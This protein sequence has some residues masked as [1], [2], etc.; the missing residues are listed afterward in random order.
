MLGLSRKTGWSLRLSR[1]ALEVSV[2]VAGWLLGGAVGVGTVLIA[3]TISPLI[4]FMSRLTGESLVE[5]TEQA[6]RRS[7]TIAFSRCP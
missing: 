5:P 1:T 7:I 6:S 3:L 2:L 4:Q